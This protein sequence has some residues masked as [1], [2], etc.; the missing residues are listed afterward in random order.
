M[1]DPK[2]T[3][4]SNWGVWNTKILKFVKTSCMG[5]KNHDLG[6][7]NKA[8]FQRITNLSNHTHPE[9]M[10]KILGPLAPK[11]SFQLLEWAFG[12]SCLSELTISSKLVRHSEHQHSAL[13]ILALPGRPQTY[14]PMLKT[15]F[16]KLKKYEDEI[17]KSALYKAWHPKF[18]THS[19][20]RWPS[21]R[22]GRTQGRT[23][24]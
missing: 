4:L 19:N 11:F 18:R 9:C 15:V 1:Y 16:H 12:P 2:T 17:Q 7:L 6:K 10:W 22:P 5:C 23:D 24:K 3:N 13:L 8:R 21:I 20:L 14:Y